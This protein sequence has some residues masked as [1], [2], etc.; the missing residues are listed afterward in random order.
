VDLDAPARLIGGRYRLGPVVGRG[1]MGIV[2]QARDELLERD[3]AVKE[4]TWPPH[5]P[6]GERES[7]RRRAVRSLTSWRT[8][9]PRAS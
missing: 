5:L 6:P 3:V 4:L 1:G 7:A 2:W 9:S 8:M